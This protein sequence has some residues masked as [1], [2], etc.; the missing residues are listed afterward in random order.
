MVE[1][2]AWEG[3][4]FSEAASAANHDGKERKAQQPYQWAS[5]WQHADAAP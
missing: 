1:T 5:G 3:K 2:T 4:N